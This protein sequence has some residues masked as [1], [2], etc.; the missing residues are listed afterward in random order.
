MWKR[1]RVKVF[2]ESEGVGVLNEFGEGEGMCYGDNYLRF[3]G[4][5]L[6]KLTIL[7]TASTN[8][9][10]EYSELNL[11]E[12]SAFKIVHQVFGSRRV[13]LQISKLTLSCATN[14][15]IQNRWI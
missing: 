7:S 5:H 6:V 13:K 3:R 14:I 10:K 11:G 15:R 1:N 12:S 8:G 4:I 2:H 9:S